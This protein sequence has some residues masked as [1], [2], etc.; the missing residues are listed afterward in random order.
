MRSLLSVHLLLSAPLLLATHTACS[1][2]NSPL[3]AAIKDGVILSRVDMNTMQ[4]LSRSLLSTL[5]A[6]T[7]F[8]QT[9][10]KQHQTPCHFTVNDS[11]M[12][13]VHT[14]GN[15]VKIS[16]QRPQPARHKGK[17]GGRVMVSAQ[18]LQKVGQGYW[19][20]STKEKAHEVT[21]N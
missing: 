4:I 13:P 20:T 14:W 11:N 7:S 18:Q 1:H 2:K 10:T 17:E 12:M 9:E 8:L 21:K 19:R 3:S 6:H 15:N 16:I 5:S